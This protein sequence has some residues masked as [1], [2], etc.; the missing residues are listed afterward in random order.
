MSSFRPGY[1]RF[2]KLLSTD[3]SFQNFRR[4]TRLRSRLL[5][6]KQDE[7]CK[8]EQE[9]DEID[10]KEPHELF[11]G[12]MRMDSNVARRDKVAE[13]NIALKDFGS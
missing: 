7:L 4:F 3:T 1:P 10:R 11:L 9:L 5:L 8:L 6:Q 12:C 2:A 13:I